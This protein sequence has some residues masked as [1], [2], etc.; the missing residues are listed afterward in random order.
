MIYYNCYSD[1]CRYVLYFHQVDPISTKS[2]TDIITH[3]VI[4]NITIT[5]DSLDFHFYI[6]V[7]SSSLN[8]MTLS[9]F[10]FV[11]RS[12]YIVCT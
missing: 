9:P 4:I 1:I 8:V 3:T 10:A 6:M 2:C 5:P 11:S 12:T 7:I